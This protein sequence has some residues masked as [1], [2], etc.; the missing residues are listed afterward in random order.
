[1]S[2]YS[3]AGVLAGYGE[4]LQPI[5]LDILV[6]QAVVFETHVIHSGQLVQMNHER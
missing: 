5:T 2:I 6:N 4:A 1:M 3:D